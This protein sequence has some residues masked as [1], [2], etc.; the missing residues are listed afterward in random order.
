MER[1]SGVKL[2]G[3][4]AIAG[5]LAQLAFAGLPLAAPGLS[6]VALLLS[7]VMLVLAVAQIVAGTG[8]YRFASWAWSAGVAVCGL[9]AILNVA[10]MLVNT[11]WGNYVG[12]FLSGAVL[13]YLTTPDVKAALG[14]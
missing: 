6:V 11:S 13:F 5:G 9:N 14:K 1:P 3:M 7:V 12:V 10:A 4:A 8:L 2:A